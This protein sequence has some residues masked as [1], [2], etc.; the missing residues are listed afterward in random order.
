MFIDGDRAGYVNSGQTTAFPVA[1][2]Q[3]RVRVKVD[4]MRSREV[5]VSVPPGAELRCRPRGGRFSSFPLMY[6]LLRRSLQLDSEDSPERRPNAAW[7]LA[8]LAV[9]IALT[10]LVVFVAD[11]VVG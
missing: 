3:H 4:W 1:P 8:G 10:V 7:I 5:E 11:W 2:G 6:V 9:W